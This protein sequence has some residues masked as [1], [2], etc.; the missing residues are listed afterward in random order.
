MAGVISALKARAR[1]LHRQVASGNPRAVA[2]VRRLPELADGDV[3]AAAE[4]TRRRH[5]LAT[6]ARELGFHGWGGPGPDTG[7]ADRTGCGHAPATVKRWS[8]TRWSGQA[9]RRYRRRPAYDR[10]FA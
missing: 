4:R 7:P 8:A 9:P 5:C 6:L 1:I 10:R 3:H 2:R